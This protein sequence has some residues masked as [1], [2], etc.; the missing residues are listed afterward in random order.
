MRMLA[1]RHCCIG[2]DF[3]N[4]QV[5]AGVARGGSERPNGGR[6]WRSVGAVVAT[7]GTA[8]PKIRGHEGGLLTPNGTV[9]CR[10]PA[11]C[12]TQGAGGGLRPLD[13]R[14]EVQRDAAPVRTRRRGGR[15]WAVRRREH[16]RRKVAG[17]PERTITRGR[18]PASQVLHFVPAFQGDRR[19]RPCVN[20][21]CG[22][23]EGLARLPTRTPLRR[24]AVVAGRS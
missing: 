6:P 19:G 22:P 18:Q 7:A 20:C 24:A 11:P 15:R 12:A 17:V 1:H 4:H 21:C 3:L 13:P 8:G 2:I 9:R 23:A 14:T 16:E 10:E 5:P